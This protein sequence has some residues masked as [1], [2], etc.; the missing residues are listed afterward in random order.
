VLLFGANVK[1]ANRDFRVWRDTKLVDPISLP[2]PNQTLPPLRNDQRT[3]TS[4]INPES[5]DL[6]TT[7]DQKVAVLLTHSISDYL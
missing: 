5:V 6:L 4:S 7:L 2:H 3:S 1:A